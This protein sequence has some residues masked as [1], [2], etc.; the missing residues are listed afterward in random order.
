M[1]PIIAYF[2]VSTDR[3]GKSG[4]GLE[5]QRTICTQFAVQNGYEITQEYTEVETGKGSNALDRRP[6][7]SAALTEAK[8]QNC[9][10]LVAKL[11]RL[12]R[13]VAFISG[14]MA[15]QVPFIGF[16]HWVPGTPYLIRGFRGHLN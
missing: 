8:K 15:K 12:S 6:Q 14:L 3:Q 10:V 4:L 7:L 9:S 2:R 1:K 13:D 11:D 5:A 16:R